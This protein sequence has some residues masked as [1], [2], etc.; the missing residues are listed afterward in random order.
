[1]SKTEEKK[2][3][4]EFFKSANKRIKQI[5]S[6]FKLRPDR[7]TE[8]NNWIKN[9]PN[10]PLPFHFYYKPKSKPRLS[11]NEKSYIYQLV[12]NDYCSSGDCRKKDWFE[13]YKPECYCCECN[14]K[15]KCNACRYGDKLQNKIKSWQ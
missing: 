12:K 14:P 8:A 1:M 9:N 15:D 6:N 11:D 3:N 13:D 5:F 10:K 4:D 7:K 2:R